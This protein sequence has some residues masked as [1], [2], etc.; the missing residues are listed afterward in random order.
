MSLLSSCELSM[1]LRRLLNYPVFS[2][3]GV[4]EPILRKSESIRL[5]ELFQIC[6]N[7]RVIS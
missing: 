7:I 5:K 2:D 6:Y 1:G 4:L 3:W